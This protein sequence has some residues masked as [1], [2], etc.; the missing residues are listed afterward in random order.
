MEGQSL[1]NENICEQHHWFQV[2]TL[3]IAKTDCPN[4]WI[5]TTLFVRV[6]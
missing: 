4:H 3:S 2:G 5:Y 6:V 1:C